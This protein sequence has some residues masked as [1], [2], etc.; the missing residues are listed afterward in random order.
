MLAKIRISSKLKVGSLKFGIIPPLAIGIFRRNPFGT[1]GS[2]SHISGESNIAKIFNGAI[3]QL[4]VS[5]IKK[6]PSVKRRTTLTSVIKPLLIKT[7][8]I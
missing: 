8:R 7:S 1:F 4:P 6:G 2:V 3:D 5:R